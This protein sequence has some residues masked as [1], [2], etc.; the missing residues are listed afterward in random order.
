M[1]KKREVEFDDV[2]SE[3]VNPLRSSSG[4]SPTGGAV[5]AVAAAAQTTP[6]MMD[7]E[8]GEEL[9]RGILHAFA[10]NF[11]GAAPG[12]YKGTVVGFL[13]LNIPLQL[14]AGKKAAAWAVLL[15]FI[16][17]LAM[18]THCYPLHSGGLVVVEGL[19]MGLAPPSRL[20]HEVAKNID[21]LL[22]VTFMVAC[23]HFLKN[24]L[25]WVFTNILLKLKSK[26]ALSLAILFVSAVMS[27]FLDALSVSAVL[28]SVCHGVLGIYYHAVENDKLELSLS[29]GG[30]HDTM[31][32]EL[33][34]HHHHHHQDGAGA[35]QQ[36]R[37]KPAEGAQASGSG[38]AP[39]S[40]TTPKPAYP[41]APLASGPQVL[42]PAEPKKEL[43]EDDIAQFQAFLRSLLVHGAIG[44]AIGG[45][46][47]IV[48]RRRP[49]RPLWRP[50]WLRFTYVTLFL[51]RNIETQR[52]R[53]GGATEP[54]DREAPGMGLRGL[55][56]HDGARL[57][58]RVARRHGDVRGP[59]NDPGRTDAHPVGGGGGGDAAAA[60]A[61]A[62][63]RS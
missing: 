60:A 27:A 11:M 51:S 12:W 33:V 30:Q 18:T 43:H 45:C 35:E 28:I 62:A 39:L 13:L 2:D 37:G 34:P 21:I 31:A 46:T 16:F 1:S 41:G 14:V 38:E 53:V 7:G 44:T 17:T 50:F 47:T 32:F 48:V 9:D 61:A 23:V 24:L 40:P 36:Q 56:R 29:G 5:D 55:P 52:T 4:P 20:E 59:G 54:G 15:E 42:E 6:D 57:G 49:L 3:M 25:L 8:D 10:S 63:P 19:L 58:H 26:V 22:L